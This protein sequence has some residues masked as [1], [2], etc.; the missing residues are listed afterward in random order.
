MACAVSR[1][2][3]TL[4]GGTTVTV[5]NASSWTNTAV[6]ALVL[7]ADRSTQEDSPYNT[8]NYKGLFKTGDRICVTNNY[9]AWFD[10]TAGDGIASPSPP[11]GNTWNRT[12]ELTGWWSLN[13]DTATFR[14]FRTGPNGYNNWAHNELIAG[15]D[16]PNQ[17]KS[18]WDAHSPGT[19]HTIDVM[20]GGNRFNMSS[21]Y[22]R[23]TPNSQYAQ[24][25]GGVADSCNNMHYKCS[26][27]MSS[28]QYQ[29]DV[30][31]NSDS[32]GIANNIYQNFPPN[33]YYYPGQIGP[34]AVWQ[35]C[36]DPYFNL[37]WIQVQQPRRLSFGEALGRLTRWGGT[38]AGLPTPQPNRR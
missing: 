26:Y 36:S 3:Q 9:L 14:Y 19:E 16:S 21:P 10:N 20:V 30:T 29:V 34:L 32:N 11:Y 25:L 18:W 6:G 37:N 35:S 38:A 28:Q 1:F 12:G 4:D 31:D 13:P 33:N 7:T 24:V 23:L 17:E 27:R 15:S 5:D 2:N 22:V 8:P